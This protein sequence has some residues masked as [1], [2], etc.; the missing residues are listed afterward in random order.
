MKLSKMHRKWG[1]ELTALFAVGV[2]LAATSIQAVA[3][4]AIVPQQCGAATVFDFKDVNGFT[5]TNY[6]NRLVMGLREF[7]GERAYVIT[8]ENEKFCDTYWG[9]VTPKFP[10]VAGKAFAVKV[11]TKS[12]A[13]LRSAKPPSAVLWYAADGKALL[14]QDALGQDS[15]VETHMPVRTSAAAYRDYAFSGVVPEG[16]S[17]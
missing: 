1:D 14:A 12:D 6:R 7:D 8:D 3:A 9:L 10:V 15:P 11:R 17:P 5:V 13:P 16:A 2:M 4:A